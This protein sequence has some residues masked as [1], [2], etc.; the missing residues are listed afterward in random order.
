MTE[1]VLQLAI[2]ERRFTP[3]VPVAGLLSTEQRL[4]MGSGDAVQLQAHR[5]LDQAPADIATV[6][7]DA[8]SLL[9]NAD[10][11]DLIVDRP[12]HG[13]ADQTILRQGRGVVGMVAQEKPQIFRGFLE[14]ALGIGPVGLLDQGAGVALDLNAVQ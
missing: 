4:E 8:E 14:V 12:S 11:L 5:K 6:G 10:G 2:L 13:G 3:L 9:E 7:V 1:Q